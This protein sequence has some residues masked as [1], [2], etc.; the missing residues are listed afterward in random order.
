MAEKALVVGSTGFLGGALVAALL[1]RG[2]PVRAG[3]RNA[4]DAARL[5]GLGAE[6]ALLDVMDPPSLR[7]AARGCSVVYHAG[8]MNTMCPREPGR[9]YE[10]NVQGAQNLIEA[11]AA[12]GVRRVVYTSSAATIGEARGT[13]ATEDSLHRGW[14]LSHYERSKFLGE[15][16]VLEKGQEHDIEVVCVNPSSVQ[17][18]GRTRGT[19]RW[20]ISYANGKLRWMVDTRISLVAIDDC[21]RAHLLAATRG[22]AGRRYLV[23]GASLEIREL[24]ALVA[25]VSGRQ[26]A[27]HLVPPWVALGAGSLVGWAFEAR[28][29]RPPVCG[30]M[31]R[32]LL[33][34]HT[35]DG[36][37]AAQELGF[38]YTPMPEFVRT[39]LR[40]YADQGLVQEM[41]PTRSA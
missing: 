5:A 39:T 2:S 31:V 13:V 36:T 1:E 8:G 27:V 35:Y 38:D 3:V 32:T 28:R 9:L 23:N 12:A 7:E 30:E 19:A 26:R 25:E 21:T 14:F 37:R 10:V 33:H 34:G 40:W 18:P 17:G 20:L 22:R 16:R 41:V 4:A 11:A 6:P 15:E 24:M 29:R